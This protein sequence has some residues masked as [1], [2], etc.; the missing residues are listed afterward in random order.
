MWINLS[1]CDNK[2]SKTNNKFVV[3]EARSWILINNNYYYKP[4]VESLSTLIL[5][6]VIYLLFV[7]TNYNF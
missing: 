2:A 3:L 1:A 6:Q 4:V 7:L 5:L